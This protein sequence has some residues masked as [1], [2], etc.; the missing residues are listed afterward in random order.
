[1]NDTRFLRMKEIPNQNIDN[2]FEQFYKLNDEIKK[3]NQMDNYANEL[4][5]LV[6]IIEQFFRCAYVIIFDEKLTTEQLP[7]E[8]TINL[9]LLEDIIELS[10]IYSLP[11]NRTYFKS[12]VISMSYMF[13]NITPIKD[14]Q[15][16]IPNWNHIKKKHSSMFGLRHKIIHTAIPP[17]ISHVNILKYYSDFEHLFEDILD[18]FHI[19]EYSFHV[20][21]GKA[22]EKLDKTHDTRN[23]ANTHFE[24]ALE[25]FKK[26]LN[27]KNKP[28][29]RCKY[30]SIKT[31]NHSVKEDF[32]IHRE[33]AWIYYVQEENDKA[34]EYM[35][36]AFKT[37][38]NDITTCFGKANVLLRKNKVDESKK[39]LIWPALNKLLPFN[40]C[41]QMFNHHI[42]RVQLDQCLEWIDR[43]IYAN[44]DDPRVYL[45][46]YDLLLMMDM[47]NCAKSCMQHVKFLSKQYY[48]SQF[49]SLKNKE[50]CKKMLL[51]RIKN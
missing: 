14:L 16:K 29:E 49:V 45:I 22:I 6:T 18:F 27:A 35:D 46:K 25:N 36:K 23:R 28:N 13:E 9:P 39:L 11:D 12:H 43:G 32:S 1:M 26:C 2:V 40:I 41:R 37:N 5:N 34:I 51:E 48:E 31:N 30:S 8:V 4:V 15:K 3:K 20:L 17:H 21:A 33:M 24:K 38:A 47:K 42:S 19:P 50:E 10:K 44:P 7:H